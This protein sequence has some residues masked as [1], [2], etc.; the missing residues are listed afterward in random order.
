MDIL[1]VSNL[2][3]QFGNFTA[4]NGISFALKEGE[5]LGVLGPNGAG[6]TTTIQMLLGILS[7]SSGSIQYF[8]KDLSQHKEMIL[9]KVN[10]SSTYTNLMWWLSVKENLHYISYLYD[11]PNRNERI[12]KIVKQFRLEELLN[13]EIQSLS[14]GQIT[15]VNLAKAF[16]NY[17]KILL[18]DEPTASLDIEIAQYIREML[19][20]QR[21]EFN[22]SIILT[23]HNMAEIEEL[24]DR[25]IVINHGKIVANDKPHELAKVIKIS[26]IQ[27]VVRKDEE[28]LV[29]YCEKENIALHK[30]RQLFE[31]EVPTVSIAKAIQDISKLGIVY[32]D[33][34]IEKPSLEEYFLSV[35]GDKK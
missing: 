33:L 2:T 34:S 11:I 22:V 9:D 12:K 19:L 10:F 4:V 14:A 7:P 18:L 3:K 5:I 15:R 29:H 25:V 26:H 27:L 17:P 24:C 35:V 23:S 1:E 32:D 8:G 21:K 6:K 31:M 20:Q 13:K 28:K 30:H 16:L